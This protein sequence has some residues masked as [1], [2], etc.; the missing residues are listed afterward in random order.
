MNLRNYTSSVPVAQSI[1][2][3][4]KLLVDLGALNLS[5]WYEKKET[6]G[7]SFQIC[8]KGQ[9]LAV[10]LP[11]KV[12]AVYKQMMKGRGAVT[13][14]VRQKI[15]IQSCR[16]AWKTLYELVQIQCDLI[17]LEQVEIL[18]A[19]L[20]YVLIGSSDTTIFDK[21]NK[22]IRLLGDGN[23]ILELPANN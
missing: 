9:M 19:F 1:Q 5:K 13:E 7:I 14:T 2:N 8:A 4:E 6:A 10:K 15:K 16:T 22:E 12:D 23:N 17:M 21:V 18:E 11:S 20:P 3:I